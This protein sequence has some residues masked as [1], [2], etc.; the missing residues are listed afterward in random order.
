MGAVGGGITPHHLLKVMGTSTCDIVVSP[1][2]GKPE[3]LIS[4]ICGQ[5]DGSVIPGMIGYEAG[6]SA[7]GDVYAWFKGLL[8][9]PLEAILPALPEASEAVKRDLTSRIAERIMPALEA[10]AAALE[11]DDTVPLALDWLNGRRTPDANQ[12]LTGAISGLRL[13][14]DAPRIY[15]SL[16]EATAFGS[17]AIVERFRAQGTRIDGAI[18]IGG[19][20]KK[21]RF[22]MQTIA[23]VMNLEVSVS[24]G[25]QTVA[26]GAAMFAAT[27]AGLYPQIEAAQ[28][29]M[30]SGTEAVYIPDPERA[31]RYDRR[32]QDYLALGA[33]VENEVGRRVD[34]SSPK[35]K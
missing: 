5:V 18:A 25:D 9:W 19:V 16:V 15:R 13:G 2:A 11:L 30:S 17:R 32:Y 1:P 26:L 3:K 10:G 31:K 20:A 12:R 34:E 22:V 21:S 14:T 6:Q 24:A 23:D 35:T 8:L 27:A 28:K 33:F 29:A 4:G 7:F